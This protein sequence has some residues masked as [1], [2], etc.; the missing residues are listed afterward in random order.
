LQAQL[1]QRLTRAKEQSLLE[2][3]WQPILQFAKFFCTEGLGDGIRNALLLGSVNRK[4]SYTGLITFLAF[5]IERPL[6]KLRQDLMALGLEAAENMVETEDHI[7]CF[8]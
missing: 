7:A 4:Y 5:S 6:V 3:A 8:V 2:E 1:L